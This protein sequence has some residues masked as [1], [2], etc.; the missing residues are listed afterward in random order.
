ME[1]LKK[2][3]AP[4]AS[5]FGSILGGILIAFNLLLYVLNVSLDSSIFMIDY[6]IF[7]GVLFLGIKSY[8]DATGGYI[9][10]GRSLALGVLICVFASIIMA[11]YKFIYFKFIDTAGID[12]LF[13]LMQD[14]WATQG[15]DE[16]KT[17]QM[18]EMMKKFMGPV[19]M[20]VSAVFE[21]VFKGVILSLILSIFLKK[22]DKSFEGTF[23]NEQ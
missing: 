19:F 7:I 11:F 8:R 10:Y 14:K 17:E 2:S 18:I 3:L 16:D 23:K 15:I 5:K 6:L 4:H 9:T 13:R 21:V 1:E 12:K 20:A 22:Q